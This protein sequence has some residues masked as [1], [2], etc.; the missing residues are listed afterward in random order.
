MSGAMSGATRDAK[1]AQ[2]LRRVIGRLAR[3]PAGER[4]PLVR[5]LPESVARTLH[6]CW[7]LWAH[8]GQLP[9]R[10]DWDLWLIRAGRGFGKTRAGAEW[11]Q[12]Y[13]RANVTARIALV[14]ATADDVRQVMIEGPSGLL[15]T[16]WHGEPI[17][18]RREAGEVRFA[19]GAMAFVY[20]AGAPQ[21]LRGPEHHAAWCDELAKWRHG[22][23]TWDNL[24]LGMRLGVRPQVVVTTTPQP[25]VLMRRVM[26]AAGAV[27]RECR[28][29]IRCAGASRGGGSRRSMRGWC[30]WRRGGRASCC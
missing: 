7:P 10:A 22:E 2:R 30:G 6:D 21:R 5:A 29:V 26:T 8:P 20:S 1:E 28:P 24:V 17:L 15:A 19:S 25:T 9:G 16:A 12:A 18:W 23:A 11:V 14:G 13:A 3:L 27:E 4:G